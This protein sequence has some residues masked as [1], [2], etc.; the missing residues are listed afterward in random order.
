M[1]TMVHGTLSGDAPMFYRFYRKLWLH[2]RTLRFVVELA[3]TLGTAVLFSYWI[4]GRWR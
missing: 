1:A 3:A 4:L 2:Y